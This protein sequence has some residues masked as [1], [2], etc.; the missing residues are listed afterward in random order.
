MKGPPLI[1][2]AGWAHT[3]DMLEQLNSRLAR[4]FDV[5]PTS[6]G[7]LWHRGSAAESSSRYAAGLA[8]LIH[9]RRG[10]ALVAGWSMGGMIALETAFQHRTLIARLALIG[11]TA[12]FFLRED[13]FP[14]IP[15]KQLRAMAL[16]FRRHPEQTLRR[17][18]KQVAAPGV[19]PEET[20]KH[21]VAA[22]SGLAPEELSAGLDY[23]K[24]TDLRDC[25]PQIDVPTLI[26]HGAEDRIVPCQAGEWLSRNLAGA[27]WRPYPGAGHALPVQ[28]PEELAEEIA[29]FMRGDV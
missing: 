6:T 11:A 23:L 2:I 20:L 15:V 4:E 9:E 24:Q 22:A 27:R 26:L 19:E 17:F 16:E 1:V 14:G 21:K 29:G 18:F 13:D 10:Q 5:V 7:E 25:L 12:R 3:P 28:L 8:A